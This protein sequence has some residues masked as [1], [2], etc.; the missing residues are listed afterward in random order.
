MIPSQKRSVL[1]LDQ[2]SRKA[3]IRTAEELPV[4]ANGGPFFAGLHAGRHPVGKARLLLRP[5]K[6]RNAYLPSLQRALYASAPLTD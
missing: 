3:F 5:A 1:S 2:L 4:P 6:Q